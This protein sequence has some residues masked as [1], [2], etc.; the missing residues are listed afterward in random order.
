MHALFVNPAMEHEKLERIV[1][2]LDLQTLPMKL[3]D[4]DW[5]TKDQLNGLVDASDLD[6]SFQPAWDDV[7]F[8]NSCDLQQA[9]SQPRM[10]RIAMATGSGR[11]A[12]MG[13]WH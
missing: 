7:W 6:L 1:E 9:G 12:A 10:R 5:I 8:A 11:Q 3:S 13:C 4:T 2:G